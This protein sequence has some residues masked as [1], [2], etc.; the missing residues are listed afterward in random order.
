[1]YF[2]HLNLQSVS[3]T[4]SLTCLSIETQKKRITPLF[5]LLLLHNLSYFPILSAVGGRPCPPAGPIRRVLIRVC[6]LSV[7][8]CSQIGRRAA[9]PPNTQTPHTE[10]ADAGPDST[11]NVITWRVG[12]LSNWWTVSLSVCC[13]FSFVFSTFQCTSGATS[14]TA[15]LGT[16]GSTSVCIFPASVS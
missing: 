9:E 3:F 11:Y 12:H 15:Q 14:H 8:H 2:V 6:C 13:F 5:L 10:D 7:S 4:F 16:L 1:M